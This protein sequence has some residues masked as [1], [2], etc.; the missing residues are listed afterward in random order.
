MSPAVVDNA[1]MLIFDDA[2][3]RTASG[4]SHG[5]G[6][7]LG[8]VELTARKVAGP[9]RGIG[10]AVRRSRRIWSQVSGIISL[11]CVVYTSEKNT[12]SK[13]VN[14][15][16]IRD[17]TVKKENKLVHS[18]APGP[19]VPCRV[20]PRRQRHLQHSTH[21]AARATSDHPTSTGLTLLTAARWVFAGIGRSQP[22]SRPPK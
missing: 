14:E 10:S 13:C 3:Y 16:L 9:R 12:T 19:D 4:A 8:L 22:S 17:R 2:L 7:A 21:D 1:T 11:Y 15:E 5:P 6:I 20:P 18:R